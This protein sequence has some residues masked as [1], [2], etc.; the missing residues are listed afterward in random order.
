MDE[1]FDLN[2]VHIGPSDYVP[3]LKDKKV[4]HI[5]IEGSGFGGSPLNL[6]LKLDVWDLPNS[7]GVVVDAIRCAKI[8]L[9][10][11]LGGAIVGP[12]AYYMKSPPQQ[13]ADDKARELTLEFIGDR[14]GGG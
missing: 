12:S 11:G 3:W 14:R 7:A 4:A 1:G 5:R 13:F 8:A 6:E 9:D 2:N 10:R